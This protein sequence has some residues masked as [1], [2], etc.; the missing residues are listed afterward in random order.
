MQKAKK[1]LKNLGP[2]FQGRIDQEENAEEM[3]CETRDRQEWLTAKDGDQR[4]GSKKEEIKMR[5]SDRIRVM[6]KSL[7]AC[8]E[9]TNSKSMQVNL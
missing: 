5:E 7:Q 6:Y 3:S 8:I 9:Q 2:H 4:A 1:N